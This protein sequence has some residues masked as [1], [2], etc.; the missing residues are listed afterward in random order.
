M[1][2]EER[3]NYFTLHAA[4][5]SRKQF[6]LC[7]AGNPPRMH[8][9]RRRRRPR[10]LTHLPSASCERMRFLFP[11]LADDSILAPLYER[12]P[13]GLHEEIKDLETRED[14]KGWETNDDQQEGAV[15]IG[16]LF[17]PLPG[18]INFLVGLSIGTILILSFKSSVITRR[19]TAPP[20]VGQREE[21]LR[22]VPWY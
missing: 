18:C 6:A 13:S 1:P 15:I 10:A 19:S 2:A 4:Q 21:L 16:E 7:F 20:A 22:K 3:Q 9:H 8:A 12:A 11:L 5:P 17:R 14:N